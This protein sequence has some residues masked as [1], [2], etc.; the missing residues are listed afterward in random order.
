[1]ARA[2]ARRLRLSPY[3]TVTPAAMALV[4]ASRGGVRGRTRSG[5]FVA[6]PTWQDMHGCRR[7][8]PECGIHVDGPSRRIHPATEAPERQAV[9]LEVPHEFVSAQYAHDS[10]HGAR[11]ERE[12]TAHVPRA[13]TNQQQSRMHGEH[14]QRSTSMASK[15]L[16]STARYGSHAR[17]RVGQSDAAKTLIHQESSRPSRAN[18]PENSL[19]RRGSLFAGWGCTE[20]AMDWTLKGAALGAGLL[21]FVLT[22]LYGP[23][24]AGYVFAGAA[25]AVILTLIAM[26]AVHA[27]DDWRLDHRWTFRHR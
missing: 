17:G 20:D 23:V 13:T 26:E 24:F 27:V 4:A 3:L 25:F 6:C 7:P 18:A 14:L 21:G 9:R 16:A 19:R 5:R 11:R 10:A 2:R 12:Q 1:M 22:V 8:A 15:V